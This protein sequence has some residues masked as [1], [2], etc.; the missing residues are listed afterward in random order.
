MKYSGFCFSILLM[1]IFAVGCATKPPK[2]NVLFKSAEWET[3]A[4]VRDLAK[5]KTTNLSIDLTA[6]RDEGARLEVTAFLGY[7]VGTAVVTK[8]EFRFLLI[9]QK[10]F[11]Y[12]KAT[13]DALAPLMKLPIHPMTLVRVAFDQPI[14][15][16]GWSCRRDAVGSIETCDNKILNVSIKWY[17]RKGFA[18]KVLL[19]SPQFE[20]DWVFPEPQTNVQYSN[21]TFRLD[22]PES[23]KKIKLN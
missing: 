6:I 1:F 14:I 16:N 5:G 3:K 8:N 12:G 2:D 9:P 4:Q 7:Q 22:A 19:A 10:R 11:Y 20:M 21:E 18:K 13:E 17:D 23:F 15:G